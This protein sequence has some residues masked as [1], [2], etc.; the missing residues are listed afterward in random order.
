MNRL[1]SLRA[2]REFCVTLNRTE[3]IDPAGASC[4]RSATSTRSSPPA[5]DRRAARAG[6]DQ[7]RARPHVLL[8]RLLGLG[9]PRGRRR[10]R[11]A[12][13]RDARSDGA[14]DARSALYEGTVTPPPHAVRA[15]VPLPAVA[16]TSTSPSCRGCST[17][18]RCGRR[19]ARAR[20]VP[21]R[22][23]PRRP[24]G[25]ARRRR[26]RAR[27]GAPR[28]PAR[29]ARCGCS[30]TCATSATASTRSASTTA[31]R[32]RRALRGGRRRGH[33]HA[34]GRAPRLRA[35]GAASAARARRR[36]R[37][38]LHVSPFM[39]MDRGTPGA[40][41]R[42]ATRPRCRSR[43]RAARAASASSTPRSRCARRRSRARARPRAGPPPR[44]DA[45]RAGRGSTPRRC[46]AAALKRRPRP[47]PARAIRPER[48]DDR[49]RRPRDRPTRC[50]ARIAT[51]ALTSSRAARRTA[52][53]AARREPRARVEVRSP[54]A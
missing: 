33:E 32:R 9:L 20:C 39:P 2:D 52:S 48:H 5:G 25:A 26:A 1:Q 3:A 29:R 6:R 43:S 17:A 21:P 11:P 35:A 10:Q 47:S 14:R 42:R 51:G 23:L 16:C 45:A 7:R 41:P 15:R 18:I 38:A 4:A 37:K 46:V 34:V 54:R 28:Q 12:R 19:G 27:A 22:R 36:L 50:C 31:S 30:P 53:A 49:A 8:R 24:G 44:D 13:A 40:S